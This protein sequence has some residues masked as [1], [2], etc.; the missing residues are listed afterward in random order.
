MPCHLPTT[1]TILN[2]VFDTNADILIMDGYGT[3]KL[4]EIILGA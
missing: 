1:A 3:P 2:N 4:R